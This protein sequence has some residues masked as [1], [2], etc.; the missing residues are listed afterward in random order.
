MR[1]AATRG[2]LMP[3]SLKMRIFAI[4]FIG[5]HVPL[6][7]FVARQ[8]SNGQV[9]GA[10]LAVLL[11]A[12]LVGTAGALYG[13]NA[14]LSP[15]RLSIE[16]IDSI[17]RGEPVSIPP[18]E[19]V[20]E[21][22]VLLRRVN[23]AAASVQS[24]LNT[25]D[26]AAH[27]DP[28]TALLNR[29]GFF[30]EVDPLFAA[31]VGGAF[32]I[33]DLDRFKAVNDQFG[34]AAGDRVLRDF[35]NRLAA[36]CGRDA[37]IARWGGEEFVAFF[38]RATEADTQVR[39]AELLRSI[40]T[41]AIGPAGFPPLTFSAGLVEAGSESVERTAERADA[42]LYAAKRAGRAQVLVERDL[43]ARAVAT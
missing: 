24:R 29:R 1:F 13:I 30:A 36:T 18:I 11:V 3:Q 33:I 14:L 27:R 37:V 40:E 16:G 43:V 4:C 21:I 38:P 41:M 23:E 12:T 6:L 42:A 22:S 2:I 26:H 17:G 9:N 31:R 10:D 39:L 7:S 15:L 34:H 28:L 5:T 32:A 20:D 25:L 35:A 19:G 8:V